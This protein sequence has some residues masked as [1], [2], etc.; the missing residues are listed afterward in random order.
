MSTALDFTFEE[1][2]VRVVMIADEPWFVANDLCQVL[3]IKNARQALSR[4]DDDQKGVTSSYTLGGMQQLNVVSESGM[5]TLVL[6]SDKPE[7][8]RVRR[9]LTSEVL[10][11]LRRTGRYQMHDIEPPPTEAMDYDPV[12]LTAGVTVV[13]E[14][15]RLFGPRA[16]R[17]LW[18]QVGLPPVIADSEALFDG[19]PLAVP[20]K[21][22]LDT[23][24]YC[25]VTEA[26]AGIGLAGTDQSTRHRIGQ[27]LRMWGWR[28]KVRKQD[29]RSA[30]VFERPPPLRADVAGY[31]EGGAA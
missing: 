28:P 2:S 26:A 30:W 25:T 21:S 4:L 19:D 3:S 17:G 27:V 14:A 18:V 1:H 7:A 11:E 24:Q 15:R 20:L 13:R 23:R 31:E 12:R 5:W 9:W 29:G 8:V 10:P 6:R 16:A 22:W